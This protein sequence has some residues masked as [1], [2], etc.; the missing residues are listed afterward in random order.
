MLAVRISTVPCWI[1]LKVQLFQPPV[2]TSGYSDASDAQRRPSCCLSLA[3]D[4]FRYILSK[5]GEWHKFKGD[6]VRALMG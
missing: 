5:H 1:S 4:M 2:F 6:S 3:S